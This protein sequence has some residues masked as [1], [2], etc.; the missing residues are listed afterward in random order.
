MVEDREEF[1]LPACG[2]GPSSS[3]IKLFGGDPPPLFF[4]FPF[5]NFANNLGL[6]IVWLNSQ[7]VI[8]GQL[9]IDGSG[10]MAPCASE[11]YDASNFSAQEGIVFCTV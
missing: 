8:N 1:M 2:A 7:L 4:E 9:M 5:R 6:L 3:S 11:W 10:L